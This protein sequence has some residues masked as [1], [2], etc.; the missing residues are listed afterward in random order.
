MKTDFPDTHHDPTSLTLFGFWVYLMTD[1]I[2]FATLFASYAVL[3]TSTADFFHLPYALTETLILLTS[4]FF[5]ALALLAVHRNNRRT[6]TACFALTF[7]LG[8]A[9]LGMVIGEFTSLT[10]QGI[11]WQTNASLSAYFTLIGT[12][13][14]HIFFGLLFMAL[15]VIQ[16]LRERLIPKTIRRLT[17]LS[18][19]W[20]FSYVVWIFMFTIVYLERS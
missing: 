14:L 7:L 19:F 3:H 4:S 5:C 17:C 8:L 16:A 20:F 15:F 6:M 10:R 18:L 9:F 12:H 13:A 11:T 2:L 1:F